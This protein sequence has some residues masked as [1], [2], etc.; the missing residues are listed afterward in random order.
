MRPSLDERY[1]LSFELP[2]KSAVTGERLDVSVSGSWT[3]ANVQ[4]LEPL[5]EAVVHE[6]VGRRL[7]IDMQTLDEID[8]FGA[9]LLNRL[10]RT[11]EPSGVESSVASV[12]ERMR[13]LLSA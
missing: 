7:N 8:T 6:A 5:V 12:P 4:V 11:R 2:L 13:G 3:A 10:I 1:G 9:C